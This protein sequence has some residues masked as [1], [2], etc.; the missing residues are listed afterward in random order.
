M[1]FKLHGMRDPNTVTREEFQISFVETPWST[2]RHLLCTARNPDG[3]EI[4][5]SFENFWRSFQVALEMTP[6]DDDE[7]DF[8]ATQTWIY[9]VMEV[10]KLDA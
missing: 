8:R 6:E 7:T 5:Q 3:K 1:T 10:F 2:W 9:E 4:P